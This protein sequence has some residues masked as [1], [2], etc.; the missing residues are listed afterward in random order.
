MNE[1][2]LLQVNPNPSVGRAWVGLLVPVL[3][4]QLIIKNADGH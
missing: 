3:N 1:N 2:I 4:I